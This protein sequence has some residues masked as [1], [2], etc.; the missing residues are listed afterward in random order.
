LANRVQR[1]GSASGNLFQG[2]RQEANFSG[3]TGM[4]IISPRHWISL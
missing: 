2:A 1:R 3:V 4:I